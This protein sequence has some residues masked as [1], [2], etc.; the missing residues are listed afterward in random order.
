MNAW[1]DNVQVQFINSRQV[2]SKVDV[3]ALMHE[4]LLQ[5]VVN[6]LLASGP[7]IH[8]ILK[9]YMLIMRNITTHQ[10]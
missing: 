8:V 4:E 3:I 2:V 6:C 1:V 5:Y 9:H 7:D 10:H